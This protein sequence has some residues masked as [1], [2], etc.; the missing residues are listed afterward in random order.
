MVNLTKIYV[1]NASFFNKAFSWLSFGVAINYINKKTINVDDLR[2]LSQESHVDIEILK[3]FLPKNV[4]RKAYKTEH[5][6]R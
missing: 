2:E 5:L 6:A 4:V 1:L 3:Q